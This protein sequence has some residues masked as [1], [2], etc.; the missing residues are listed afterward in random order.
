MTF[1]EV[2][3]KAITLTEKEA[4]ASGAR[5]LAEY[6][7]ALA[8]MDTALKDLYARLAGVDPIDY[9]AEA[10]KYGRLTGLIDQLQAQYLAMAK[11]VGVA[12]KLAAERAIN[13]SY[14]R[15]TYALNWAAPK[16]VFAILDPNVVGLSVY[17]T[18]DYWDA[19]KD[20]KTF[21]PAVNYTPK[22]GTLLEQLLV[23]RNPAVLAS[24]ETT[25]RAGLMRG[26]SYVKVAKAIQVVM[27]TDAA[28]AL[29]IAQTETHRNMM[30][31]QYAAEKAAQAKGVK[32]RRMWVASLDDKTRQTHASL[33][34]KYEDD[35]G[36]FHSGGYKAIAPGHFGVASLDINCRC[37]AVLVVEDTPP[38]LRRGRDPATGK[39]DIISWTSF[40]Q[41]AKDNGMVWRKGKLVKA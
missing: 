18:Q 40:D 7:S 14:Y 24:I 9:Y 22:S 29:R 28:S 34:G 30:A 6:E 1:N 17:G 21:G 3:K 35:D 39:T 41:W 37:S 31:G 33:D 15:N 5:V 23:K 36:Y 4:D 2:C 16:R 11:K 32:A 12:T 27:E 20:T 26:D 38:E 25:V 19:I 10:A 8:E 13:N